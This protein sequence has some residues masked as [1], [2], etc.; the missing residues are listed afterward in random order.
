MGALERF[1]PST[2]RSTS[3][4]SS[5][6]PG[7]IVPRGLVRVFCQETPPLDRDGERPA[8]AGRL[9][10]LARESADGP[11]DGQPDLAAPVRPGA[12]PSPDNFGAAG[13][14]P[15]HPELLDT[16][17]VEFMAEGWSIKRLI[18]RIVLSR[19]YQ[20]ASTH[21]AAQLRGRPRQRA[22]LAD[23]PAPARGRGDPRRPA[24]GQRPAD[25]ASRRS[26]RPSLA[27]A[28]DLAVPVAVQRSTPRTRIGRSICRSSATSC[29]NRS[30]CSTSPTRAS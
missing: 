21:D 22:R 10:R 28:R 5:T 3:G 13:Q 1:E 7:E 8:R 14:P 6:E 4:A 23:E 30:P 16:L 26:A 24:R 25:A 27:P 29:P 11:G 20:L 9:A 17:A 19:A 2:A 12:R 15:S 18:R